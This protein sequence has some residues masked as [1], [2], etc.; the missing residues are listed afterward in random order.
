MDDQ[1][2]QAAGPQRIMELSSGLWASKALSTALELD[3]FGDLAA[4]PGSTTTDLARRLDLPPRPA[5][6]LLIACAALGLVDRNGER[7]F[8]TALSDQYL[9]RSRPTYFGGWV[10][11]VDKHDYQGWMELKTALIENRPTCWDPDQNSSLFDNGDPVMLESFWEAMTAVSTIT[12]RELGPWIDLTRSHALLDIGG[13]GA[14]WDIELC[15]MNPHLRATVFDL[16]HVCRLTEDK[17]AR[18]GFGDRINTVV[19]DF[20]A[21]SELPGGF[22][23]VLL[24]SIL[25][26][27]GDVD[28]CRLL[29]KCFSA[30]PPN[31]KIVISELLINDS[32]DG[33]LDAAL[34]GLAMQVE[35]WGRGFTASELTRWLIGIGFAD[36]EVIRIS[37]PAANAG[38]VARKP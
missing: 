22:D 4:H 20:F 38:V 27:W 25:H 7:C 23:T 31:G 17:I 35:T 36:V 12:A 5:R 14:A 15:R 13:G 34:M 9:V 21:D 10:E 6:S 1:P 2:N 18:A 33:P 3:I 8:N 16:A 24:S 28:C 29:R 19:G 30:L 37:A 11:M 32:E 26:D